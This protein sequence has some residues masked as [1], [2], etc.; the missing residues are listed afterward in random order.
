[1]AVLSLLT[2]T[3]ALARA[4]LAALR[5]VALVRDFFQQRA[6]GVPLWVFFGAMLVFSIVGYQLDH[7]DGS[8]V[9]A[10][11]FFIDNKTRRL[12][13]DSVMD[14]VRFWLKVVLLFAS[15]FIEYELLFRPSG[16]R[17]QLD[18]R[19]PVREWLCLVCGA[20]FIARILVQMGLFWHREISW[21]EVFA[22][23]GG[24]IPISLASFAFGAAQ[25][26]GAAVGAMEYLGVL[27]FLLGTYLNIWPE[28][29]RYV[30]KSDPGNA[31]HLYVG[32]LFAFCRHI[33]YFGE[34]LSFV[35][36]ALASSTWWNLWV[37]VVMG[38]GMAA[39]SVPELDAYLSVKYSAEWA[40]YTRDVPCQMFPFV[41]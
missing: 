35:G 5:P 3:V 28:Y 30:W 6:G 32:G 37:P 1:M 17:R 23:A 34:V 38:F 9:G 24:V 29:T 16:D 14:Y 27:V 20:T 12:S 15:L 4:D 26:R 18:K 36:F 25:R 21:I 8:D 11:A 41:W 22:E 39:F 10:S 33:N 31:G 2:I 40:A 13:A 7:M 19:P